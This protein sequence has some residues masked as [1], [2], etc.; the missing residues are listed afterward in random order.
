M[1]EKTFYKLLL[2]YNENPTRAKSFLSDNRFTLHEKKIVQGHLLLRDKKNQEVVELLSPLAPSDLKFVESQRLMLLGCAY[3]NLS[4]FE[5]AHSSLLSSLKIVQSLEVPYFK[6]LSLYN[7]FWIYANLDEIKPMEET[8]K[9]LK[10]FLDN[11]EKEYIRIQRCK[12]CFYEMSGKLEEA[13]KTLEEIETSGIALSESDMI[14]F[15]TDKFKLMVQI[16]D[17]EQAKSVLVE[18]KKYRKFQLSENYMY[19]KK[20]LV[21]LMENSPIY[22]YHDEFKDCSLLYHQ[23]KCIQN[24]EERNIP[25]AQAE[26][27]KLKNIAKNTYGSE[28]KYK[29]SKCLFSLCLAKHIGQIAKPDFQLLKSGSKL[30]KLIHIMVQ[31][32]G[33]ISAALLYELIWEENVEEKEDLKKVSRLVFRANTENELNIV[34]HKGS[35]QLILAKSKQ[36]AKKSS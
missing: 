29:G 34:Y 10:A 8:L 35:Y 11:G 16:E 14:Y 5:F 7:L 13:K 1:K 9:K 17:L 4:S 31:S 21:H 20:L 28:F 23:I 3:N 6:F 2:E 18:M 22:A 32:Q 15:L 25:E 36:A 24:L 19:M 30:E 26:W 12:L 33:A 27:L